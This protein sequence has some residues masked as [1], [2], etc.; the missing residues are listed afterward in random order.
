MIN[1][2]LGDFIIVLISLISLGVF[3]CSSN[4]D[5]EISQREVEHAQALID[6]DFKSE[7]IDTMRSYLDR[8]LSG[9][10]SLRSY[11]LP[12]ETLPALV[13]DH[14]PDGFEL[15]QINNLF[16]V[17][18]LT[19]FTRPQSNAAL[20]Y[21]TIP[22]LAYLLRSDQLSSLELTSIYLQRLKEYNPVLECAI[23]ITEELALVQAAKADEEFWQGID[24]GLLQGIPYGTKDLMAVEGYKTT[25][26]AMPY[27]DQN[28]N[29]T[30]TVIKKLND[31]GA[32]LVAKLTTG[33][34]ARGDVWFDGKTKNPWDTLQ[35]ASGSS[36]GP[37]SATAA[38]LVAFSLGTETLGS[39]TS[40]SNRNG[41]TGLRPT[42]GRVS[43]NGVMSLSWSMD[44]VGP[45]CRSA[46]DCSIVFEVIRGKDSLDVTTQQVG[47]DYRSDT[48]I[49]TLKV[50]CLQ[51]L[52]ESDTSD[53]KENLDRV[54]LLLDS[55][56]IVPTP[57]SLPQQYPF[58][59]FD[60]ILRAEAGAMFD[61]IVR[62]GEVNKMVQQSKRSRANSLRQS[63]FI[64]A[65]EY[66]QA[67]R[68]RRL[69]I[70]EV[71]DL[72]QDYDVIIAPTFGGRQLLIT[73]LTG[74]PVVT[75]PTGLDKDGYPTSITFIGNLYQE[76]PIL[77]FAH[78]YQ[79][80]TE[81]DEMRPPLFA[82]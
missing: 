31:A 14:H 37:G 21:C 3:S 39:I 64:P 69:L 29:Y 60:I 4:A 82:D 76:A 1:Q 41:I 72:F 15:P 55:M 20:A 36:A 63:R 56:G 38:G 71:N 32:V 59:A 61:D 48:D 12:F 18:D 25:W 78:A 6:L 46:E 66:L 28:L 10:D 45:M 5:D 23:T 50:A 27:K 80:I 74:H 43:R 40:P 57:I 13:F 16:S 68:F 26:G 79:S 65:V 7:Y 17:S 30:A 44:K 2:K 58:A 62:S 81:Y 9:Y 67:N 47:F 73:N 52:I 77:S 24:R 19:E 75:V 42:Y 33:A 8:N 70:N 51:D 53:A 35:G 22:Q 11:Y 54:M 34:L 49:S